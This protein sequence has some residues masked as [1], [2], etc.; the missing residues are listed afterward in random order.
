MATPPLFRL[1][2]GSRLILA[3]HSP[4]RQ[5]FL[6]SWGIPFRV[7][8]GSS[9]EIR[10]HPH[11]EAASFTLRAAQAKAADAWDT[12]PDSDL[13]PIILAAD[14]VVSI[15][16]RI[17]GKPRTASDALAMLKSLSGR[18]HSVITSVVVFLPIRPE[19]SFS[20]TDAARVR[21]LAWDEAVLSA[22]VRT[23][24]PEDKAGAYAVQGQGAFLIDEIHGSWSTVVGLPQARLAQELLSRSLL[25]PA[26]PTS[27]L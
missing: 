11:E 9:A 27:S 25:F 24:E 12:L 2:E 14:T 22:Y 10:P 26:C 16:E 15:D 3:S 20:F 8:T 19:S 7:H 21:F 23:R 6:A 18:T 17:L 1:P 4:R 5:D 13:H